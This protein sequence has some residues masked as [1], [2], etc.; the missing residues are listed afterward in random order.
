MADMIANQVIIKGDTLQLQ[1][2]KDAA[3]ADRFFSAVIAEPD[4]QSIPNEQ[5]QLPELR[6][7]HGNEM[8][9]F[10]E[11]QDLRWYEWRCTHWG[12]KWDAAVY[13]AE[14]A[15]GVLTI[16]CETAWCPPVPIF[17]LLVDA[18]LDVDWTYED[19]DVDEDEDPTWRDI[20]EAI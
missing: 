15:D 3:A 7:T 10:G 19:W 6:K 1:N 16:E 9:F 4:W 8:L 14:L 18:G 2:L 13:K 12:T 17:N 5:G 20:S 11:K